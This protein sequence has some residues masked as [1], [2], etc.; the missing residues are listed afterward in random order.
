MLPSARAR[1]WLKTLRNRQARAWRPSSVLAAASVLVRPD[2]VLDSG[3]QG[4]HVA[5]LQHLWPERRLAE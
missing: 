4:V 2:L 5:F 1:I 3:H